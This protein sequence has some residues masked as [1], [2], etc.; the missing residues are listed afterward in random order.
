M[1]GTNFL[2]GVNF[3]I[4]MSFCLAFYVVSTRSRSKTAARWIAAGFAIASLSALCELAV[5]HTDWVKIFAVGA[6]STVLGGLQ[7]L[8][9]GV[10]RLYAQTINLNRQMLFFLTWTVVDLI[11]Y[12]LSRGSVAHAILYQTPFALIALLAAQSVLKQ[13]PRG[14][15]D[16]ALAVLLI[17]TG[18]HFFAK[19]FAAI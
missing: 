15:L 7:L 18:L 11:I 4:A 3:V 13:Q 19:A 10:A 17:V 5:A 6:F 14:G 16:Q 9:I 2:L 1:N 8:Q 12:D